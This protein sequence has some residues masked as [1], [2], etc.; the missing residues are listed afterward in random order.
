[1][2]K[3]LIYL[4]SFV[5]VLGLAT[6]SAGQDIAEGLVGYWPLDEGG[7]TTTADASGNGNDGTFVDAPVWVSGKFGSALDFDGSNDAVDC[8]NQPILDFG[9]GDWTVSAWIKVATT[10]SD[11]VTI[12]GKGGDHGGGIR[13]QLMLDSSNDIHPVVDDDS[14]KY[15]PR[16][17][18]PIIDGQWH[19]IVMMRRDGTQFR[20]YVDGVEDVGVTN[21][22]ESTLPANYDLS[23]TSQHN[24]YI[25]AIT[26]NRDS[27]G[28]TLEKLFLG[29]IDDVAVWNRALTPE[30][31]SYL[32][33]NGAGNPVDVSDPGQ[34]SDP[35]LDDGAEDVPRDVV[36]SWTQ[37]DFAAPTNGH[38]V[39]FGQ[40]FNDVNDAT[41]GVAQ[42]AN[43]YTPA[44]RLDFGTTY[45]WRV[46]EVN[47]P[48]TSQIEFKGEVWS[49]TTEP[50]AYPIAGENII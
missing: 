6:T 40:S 24:A 5:L 41:G 29:L 46:D 8:G 3:K 12:Y 38:K 9:T 28:N 25:G 32:W 21:H 43:S 36:L 1:M 27:T 15:D 39:Y 35:S 47:A 19:H 50:V 4:V 26:D 11:D 18:I 13:Y 48:P 49:F 7:G 34:A 20:V 14:S 23:G 37:G 17:D 33:N 10:P 30:E 31:I 44:Q 42:D 22:G 45:Y 2:S 16:G